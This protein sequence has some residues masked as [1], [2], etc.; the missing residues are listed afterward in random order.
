MTTFRAFLVEKNEDG[1]FTR[2]VVDRELDDLPAG[3][4]L[5]DV[6]YSS[7]NYKDALSAIGNPG[8]TRSYPHTPGIDVAGT[9]LESTAANFTA[10]DEVVVIGFDLG[11]NTPGGFGERVRVPAAWAVPLPQGL[12]LEEAMILG[13]AGFTAA[14]SVHKL[15]RAGMSPEGGPILVSGA[16]GGVGSVAIKLLDQLGYEPH[17]VT[18][19]EDQH[20]FL[21]SIGAREILSREDLE[22]GGDRPLLKEL[23]GG[24]V[25]TVGGGMLFN[26]IKGLRYGQSAAACGLV[27]SPNIPATVLPFILRHVNLLGIDSV[28]LPLT[29][30]IEIWDKLAGVWKLTGLTELK[31]STLSLNTLSEAIETILDGEMVGRGVVDLSL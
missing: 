6:K 28:E 22:A 16:T 11:M 5:I 25:D 19:K 30:K 26:A 12:S 7:L 1:T 9:I 24:V 3:E 13:T 31:K 14:L 15:E 27:N 8:V 17:A 29:E 18:G 4:L 20:E 2:S 21:R 23:W 10:G